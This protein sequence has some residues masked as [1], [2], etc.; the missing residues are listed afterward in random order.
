MTIYNYTALKNN[1]EIVKGKIEADSPR[2]ARE[3]IRKLG[4]LPTKVEE[5]HLKGQNENAEKDTKK[6]RKINYF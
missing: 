1:K 6:V 3:N 5:E 2:Q 4:F